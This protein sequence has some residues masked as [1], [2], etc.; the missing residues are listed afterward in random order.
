MRVFFQ[1]LTFILLL[2][3]CNGEV[4]EELDGTANENFCPLTRLENGLCPSNVV[5][6]FNFD[7]SSNYTFSSNFIEV[8]SGRASLKTVDQVH[9][10]T[11]FL[12]GTST[13]TTLSNSNLELL[14]NI[15]SSS[16]NL[17][18]I[19]SGQ[20]S[21][22]K[23][24][25]RMDEGSGSS[26]T[27]TSGQGRTLTFNGTSS[28]TTSGKIA[29]ATVHNG[30]NYLETTTPNIGTSDFSL[31]FWLKLTTLNVTNGILGKGNATGIGSRWHLFFNT[32]NQLVLNLHDG[33]TD[34]TIT[35]GV[36]IAD[37]NWHHIAVS[38]D[39]N[40]NAFFYI[41]GL[42]TTTSSLVTNA[43]GNISDTQSLQIAR[44]GT[45]VLNGQLDE[46]AI[47]TTSL[48]QSQID[49]LYRSQNA[50]F[51][52]LSSSWTPKFSSLIGYWKMDGNFQDS[53]STNHFTP[54]S[55]T[56]F[57]TNSQVGTH[58]A[59]FNGTTDALKV[60]NNGF[61]GIATISVSMWVKIDA[62]D[63]AT[64]IFLEKISGSYTFL[65]RPNEKW[66]FTLQNASNSTVNAEST[67]NAVAGSWVHLVG[68]YDGSNIR[69]YVDG[70]LEATTAQT[71]NIKSGTNNLIIGCNGN[72]AD[73]C[74]SDQFGGE[75]DELAIFGSAVLTH[76]DVK[77]I[78][79]RQ[80]QKYAGHYD[81]KVID[82][83]TSGSWTGLSTSTI[84]PFGKQ[85]VADSAESSSDYSS[86]NSDFSNGIIAYFPL[87]EL[88]ANSVTPGGEDF[89]NL[90]S[91]GHGVESGGVSFGNNGILGKAATFDGANDVIAATPS[92]AFAAQLNDNFTSSLWLKLPSTQADTGAVT[93]TIYARSVAGGSESLTLRNQ[94]SG[95]SPNT[96]LFS[97]SDGANN[98]TLAT[99]TLINDGKFHHIVV[100]KSGTT[101]SLYID[102]KLENTATDNSS[103]TNTYSALAVGANIGGGSQRLLGTIDELAFWSRAF[104][105]NEIKELYRRGANRITYQVKSCIDSACNCKSFNAAPAGSTTDCDGDGTLNASD[106]SDIHAATFIGPGGDGST[107]Y[108]ELFNRANA[109]LTFSCGNNTSD[110][111]A[112]ICVDDEIT[113]SSHTNSTSPSILFGNMAT[114]ASLSNNRYF[115]YRVL[116]EAEDNTLCN[117]D[118]CK[119]SLSSFTATPTGRFYGG[120]PVIKNVPARAIP[121]TN[122]SAISF[123]ESGNCTLTYQ[124][125][126]DG[127]NFYYLVGST[128]T[129]AGS[130]NVSLS[131][132]GTSISGNISTFIATAG[133]GNLSFKA[134][135][136][137]DTSQSCNIDKIEV[138]R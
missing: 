123:V 86:L 117:S 30:T 72:V 9:S 12:S 88:I 13:G 79:E 75:I 74:I 31:S 11:D 19:L 48:S 94:T 35:S 64:R 90:S 73:N 36:T 125:S 87:D 122:L 97:R 46:L 17:M 96:L 78:Y 133:P 84:L 39:R 21:N 82:L 44:T 20:N 100:T 2:C 118:L 38:I 41:D 113:I 136:T 61:D 80:K 70:K 99:T 15:P 14:K 102:G 16:A 27:D 34:Q 111:N 37:N 131:S 59:H 40:A 57:T 108:S 3:S 124:L 29:N 1:Y 105:T 116:L 121:F 51:T 69:L 91:T 5:T 25:W 10:G 62:L 127:T 77:L 67:S 71:G 55:T 83:G 104:T 109:N 6:A 128:W 24:Y 106:L 56:N 23:G 58:S 132:S 65:K 63:G 134:F 92:G 42:L 7:T 89:N 85:I 26:I 107:F 50:N 52:E 119:P 137:S 112:A 32:S 126:S 95:A 135:M 81:S 138:T 53:K 114:S 47:W 22:L 110:S 60:A 66:R 28:F 76:A 103:S 45:D 101:L 49:N 93:N 130:E 33:T 98:P 120:T 68:T 4:L 115:Q 18:T 54:V 43:Q 129:L 8:G